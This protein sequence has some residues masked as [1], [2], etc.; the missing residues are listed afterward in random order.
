MKITN[1]LEV[2]LISRLSFIETME[3]ILSFCSLKRKYICIVVL[4]IEKQI[5][6][7][8]RKILAI[9]CCWHIIF[10][11]M[12]IFQWEFIKKTQWQHTCK[13][14]CKYWLSQFVFFSWNLL[15]V[16]MHKVKR[17]IPESNFKENRRLASSKYNDWDFYLK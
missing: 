4:K 3:W 12:H 6:F 7:E 14:N 16:Q 15:L 1:C 2:I 17:I 10:E 11:I 9:S 13:N 5:P 8:I